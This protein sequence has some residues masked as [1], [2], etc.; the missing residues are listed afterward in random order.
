MKKNGIRNVLAVGIVLIF[1]FGAF[2]P[3]VISNSKSPISEEEHF[4]VNDST[5][6]PADKVV[7]DSSDQERF[8]V[9]DSTL[10]PTDKVVPD[11]SDQKNDLI[12]VDNNPRG[13]YGPLDTPQT[14]Y[15]AV[16]RIYLK[17]TS[18]T[19]LVSWYNNLEQ[20]YSGYIQVFKA[21]ELYNTGTIP[22]TGGGGYDLY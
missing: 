8:Q 5:L 12:Q 18:Y 19:Q 21:N 10:H 11:S 14:F 7:P 9:N 13:G 3:A 2:A 17:P 4:Q 1:V 15:D 20:N 16:G 6:H 22:K